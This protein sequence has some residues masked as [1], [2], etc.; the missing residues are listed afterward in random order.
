MNINQIKVKVSLKIFHERLLL[1]KINKK[2]KSIKTLYK[3]SS[4]KVI[5]KKNIIMRKKINIIQKYAKKYL[6]AQKILND[7]LNEYMN[8]FTNKTNEV[9]KKINAILFP[10]RKRL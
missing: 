8:N 7:K 3:Y 9:E 4:S 6:C 2:K 5:F 10:Y 1:Y